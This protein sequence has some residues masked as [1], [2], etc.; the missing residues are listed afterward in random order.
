MLRVL[1]S[2]TFEISHGTRKPILAMEGL[3]G[4]AVFLVFLVHY[5]SQALPLVGDAG[6]SG[7]IAW[8]L[9]RYG[10]TGVD[11]FFVLSGF[12]IYGSIIEKPRPFLGFMRRRVVRIYPTFLTILAVYVALS[13]VR[14]ESSRIPEGLGAATIYLI[15]NALLLP[16]IFPIEPIITVSWSLSYELFYYLVIP[17]VVGAL[18]LR[19]RSRLARVLF[20]F[21]VS[22]GWLLSA[23]HIGALGHGRLVMFVS[24][25]LLKEALDAGLGPR[26][27][28]LGLPALAAT[29]VAVLYGEAHHLGGEWRFG[30]LFVGF[31]IL[32]LAAFGRDGFTARVFSWTP[33]R[34]LGNMSYSYYLVH[35]LILSVVFIPLGSLVEGK[36]LGVVAFWLFLG[37]MFLLTLVGSAVV[38]LLVEKP[39]S[40]GKPKP[41]SHP[42]L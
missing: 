13:F 24:G 14:P 31:L 11:L 29:V 41:R 26:A 17:L 21:I 27:D 18:G 25:I 33:M 30:C 35:G 9:Q 37:P 16:G 42:G 40:L 12:L 38:F 32:C 7:K 6:W 34:W 3:R 39:A 23:D 15:Q 4:F 36:D 22:I 20:F 28:L 19:Q 5:V 1:L 2:K 8:G 10:H